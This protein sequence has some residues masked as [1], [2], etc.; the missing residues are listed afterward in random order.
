MANESH[1]GDTRAVMVSATDFGF[2]N[3]EINGRN[4]TVRVNT[5]PAR[6]FRYRVV[7]R[8]MDITLVAISIPVLVPVLLI[9]AAVVRFTSPAPSSSPTAVSVRM[10]PLFHVEVP[11]HVRQLR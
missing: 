1:P 9:V 4:R 7:K 10:A 2:E 3:Y 11:H 5:L 8:I 6:L